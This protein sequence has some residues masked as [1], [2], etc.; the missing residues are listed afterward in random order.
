M[1]TSTMAAILAAGVLVAAPAF[2]QGTGSGAMQSGSTMSNPSTGSGMHG[3]TMGSQSLMPDQIKA[4]QEKLQQNGYYKDGMVDGIW[5]PGTHQAVQNF[6]QAH[7]LPGNGELDQQTL[8]ALGMPGG[9]SGMMGGNS[10]TNSQSGMG[11][12]SMGSSPSGSTTGQMG[13][14]SSG[15]GMSSSP[16]SGAKT[17]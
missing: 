11:S 7:N 15:S 16:S 5:G 14:G 2:A 6:Q 13:A 12:S 9:S 10:G 8:A 17:Q 1:K 3:S 4:V